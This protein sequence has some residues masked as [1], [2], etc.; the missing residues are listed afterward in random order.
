MAT[1]QQFMD[2]QAEDNVIYSVGSSTGF[3]FIGTKDE[4]NKLIKQINNR[5]FTY[6]R[7]RLNSTKHTLEY[8]L[9]RKPNKPIKVKVWEFGK[10]VE[11]EISVKEQVEEW[12]KEVANLKKIIANYEDRLKHFVDF[13]DRKI[14]S[15]Y[16][17]IDSIDGK[18]LIIEG[19]EEGAY[20]FRYEF[21]KDYK[22]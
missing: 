19:K 4:Y 6:L 2:N 9:T 21:Q 3:I 1:L 16:S 8:K 11:K 10:K 18:I 15:Y 12:K 7:Y 17:K 22:I 5:H 13:P 14:I 20:W